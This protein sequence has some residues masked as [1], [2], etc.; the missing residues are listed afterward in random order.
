VGRPALADSRAPPTDPAMSL[1]LFLE[2]ELVGDN[3]I[4][5]DSQDK[6]GSSA[7]ESSS[8]AHLV[9]TVVSSA[10]ISATVDKYKRLLG[11]AKTSLE[12]NQKSLAAKDEQILELQ[13]ALKSKER[14]KEKARR[15]GNINA[16]I[17]GDGDGTTPS[18]INIKNIHRRVDVNDSIYIFVEYDP[19]ERT[20]QKDSSE[21]E[22][23]WLSFKTESQLDEF[24]QRIPG[25]P[26]VCPAKSLTAD[27]SKHIM[28]EAN[29]RVQ[30]I[31]EE[32]RR[33]KVKSEIKVKQ[34]EAE[35][36]QLILKNTNIAASLTNAENNSASSLH[37]NIDRAIM[38]AGDKSSGNDKAL[39]ELKRH[40][41]QAESRWKESLQ[42]VVEE[43]EQLRNRGD[44]SLMAA[45]WKDRYDAMVKEKNELV[46]KL[47][48][49]GRNPQLTTDG[50]DASMK[51]KDIKDTKLDL[52]IKSQHLD[53]DATASLR[54]IEQ[55]Y[56]EL[57]DE[58]K[59]FRRRALSLEQSR[60]SEIEELKRLLDTSF[61]SVSS[62]GGPSDTT[63]GVSKA[64]SHNRQSND[65]RSPADSRTGSNTD[66]SKLGIGSTSADK[67]GNNGAHM[68]NSINMIESK[69]KY[70]KQMVLQ[71]LTCK[72]VEVRINIE[73]ALMAMFRFTD[74]EKA[75]IEERQKEENVD[76]NSILDIG[77]ISGYLDFSSIGTSLGI[78]T[79]ATAGTNGTIL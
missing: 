73:A 60:K 54:P 47:N 77:D 79:E 21:I 26:V 11:V 38:N 20:G 41:S 64:T 25:K 67:T 29:S 46:E 36:R 75:Q 44:D 33:Y 56:I 57:K 61:L 69:Q 15:G 22:D 14:K 50:K 23:E 55:L 70:I 4:M 49:L 58:Y 12:N 16:N 2:K 3:A 71:L 39:M 5:A 43:N 74:I 78:T 10:D 7:A 72:D 28:E 45:Q 37:S 13:N 8:K 66:L 9:A 24:L 63:A 18:I 6:S 42:K 19:N 65:T 53:G 76:I 34:K 31:L 35:T 59:E 17:S 62:P 68:G 40:V 27:D 51:E 52:T 30:K 1:P 32:F 48:I